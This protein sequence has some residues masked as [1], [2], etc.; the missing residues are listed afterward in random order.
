MNHGE[1]V[2]FIWGVADLIRDTFKHGKYQDVIL[3]LTVLR[4]L[5]CVLLG[6]ALARRQCVLVRSAGRC[7][8]SRRSDPGAQGRN[9]A[10]A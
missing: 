4:R 6:P 2:S 3:P 7:V 9:L 10:G 5:D 8:V 1:I